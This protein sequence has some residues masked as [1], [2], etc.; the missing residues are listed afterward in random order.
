MLMRRR[1][2]ASIAAVAALFCAIAPEARAAGP[3]PVIAGLLS[4][5]STVLPISVAAGLLLN[6]RGA[7]EGVRFD[8]SLACVA[9]GSIAGPSVGQ[10][11]GKGGVDAIVTFVLRF[12]TGGLMTTGLGLRLR[13]DDETTRSTGTAMLVLAGIPTAFLG[14]WDWFGAASSAKQ[15]RYREG[16]ASFIPEDVSPE[17]VSLMSCPRAIPCGI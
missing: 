13:S 8:I 4:A 7:D 11:Y 3:D 6:G 15:T 10:I 17:L 5:G 9:I 14:I 12:F 1:F 2:C 16:H